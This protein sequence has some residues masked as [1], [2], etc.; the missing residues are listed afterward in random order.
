MAICIYTENHIFPLIHRG[1]VLSEAADA[2]SCQ[3]EAVKSRCAWDRRGFVEHWSVGMSLY[4][5]ILMRVSLLG[6]AVVG[7]LEEPDV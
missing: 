2:R 5:V 3:I 1:V 7:R 6:W 4:F